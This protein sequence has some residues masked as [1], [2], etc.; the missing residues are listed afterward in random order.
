MAPALPLLAACGAREQPT[1]PA[2]AAATG[3]V[4]FSFWLTTSTPEAIQRV[5]QKATPFGEQFP[6][7]T[8]EPVAVVGPYAEKIVTETAG[9]SA[10]DAIMVDAYYA[11]EWFGNGMGIQLDQRMAKTKDARAQDYQ[12]AFLEDCSYQGKLFGLP[13]DSGPAVL[14]GNPN[15][16][17]RATTP[18]PYELWKADRWTL[19][20]FTEAGKKITALDPGNPAYIFSGHTS[21]T[22]WLPLIW[23]SGGEFYDAKSGKFV[24]NSASAIEALQW[25]RDL[26]YAQRLVPAP[27]QNAS[28][29]GITFNNQRIAIQGAWPRQ[30]VRYS[31]ELGAKVITMPPPAGKK[32]AVAVTKSN[33]FM[34][35]SGSKQP[36][37]AF[38]LIRAMTSARGEIEEMKAYGFIY[39]ARKDSLESK[40]FR[41][42]AQWDLNVHKHAQD[43][44]HR[45][46]LLRE[47]PWNTMTKIWDDELRKL[48][49]DQVSA[50]Q[51]AEQITTALNN[52]LAAGK[53]AR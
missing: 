18:N 51:A 19:D 30:P 46:P 35:W 33:N 45:L 16:F 5:M 22:W 12:P 4:R 6:R 52:E 50:R 34:V 38:E 44:A 29:Q 36:D 43:R 17:S 7:V 3:S 2:P 37:L 42:L 11:Q 10:S 24:A 48:W 41:D 47:V 9:G 13:T 40:E 14:A 27:S 31:D 53:G 28:A 1:A 23:G 21:F 8:V 20:A 26:I 49:N 25:N 15:L 39:P 32:G